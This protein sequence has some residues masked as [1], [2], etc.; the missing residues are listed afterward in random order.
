MGQNPTNEPNRLTLA[1]LQIVLAG[2]LGGC[3]MFL[4]IAVGMVAS[5]AAP[6]TGDDMAFLV[7]VGIAAAAVA[8]MLQWVLVPRATAATKTA[9]REKGTGLDEVRQQLWARLATMTLARAAALEGAAFLN[10]VVLL[11]TQSLVP[12]ALA[13]VLM[14]GIAAGIP[15][16]SRTDRWLDEQIELARQESQFG[17]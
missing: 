3:G 12:L 14:L 8:A 5:G 15:T 10:L 9:V 11:I 1:G 6:K 2:M 4:A 17:R 7:P 16:R 13:V